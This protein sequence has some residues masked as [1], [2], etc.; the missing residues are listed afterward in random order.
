MNKPNEIKRRDVLKYAGASGIPV[1]MSTNV[2]GASQENTIRIGDKSFIEVVVNYVGVDEY[3]SH[4]E[5]WLSHITTKDNLTL[6]DAPVTPFQNEDLVVNYDTSYYTKDEPFGGRT[7]SLLPVQ[8]DH[9]QRQNKYIS[10]EKG[11]PEP[12]ITIKQLDGDKVLAEINGES[13]KITSGQTEKTHLDSQNVTRKYQN[14]ELSI[15]PVVSVRN[16]GQLTVWGK[17][18][19]WVF[20]MGHSSLWVQDLVSS[21]T[22]E[23]KPGSTRGKATESEE[24][25]IVGI[26]HE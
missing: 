12:E 1:V 22:G 10:I 25:L 14:K 6:V 26:D 19:A 20:P 5:G 17:R 13:L 3:D 7:R 24:F 21:L 4:D 11:I 18:D 16:Y 2:V 15:K 23:K 9:S 8:T